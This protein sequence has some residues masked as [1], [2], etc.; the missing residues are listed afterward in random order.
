MSPTFFTASSAISGRPVTTSW[1]KT[2]SSRPSRSLSLFDLGFLDQE[3]QGLIFTN[4]E[5]EII[6]PTWVL[7]IELAELRFFYLHG[8]RHP[9]QLRVHFSRAYSDILGLGYS[10][11][12]EA[13]PYLGLC[14]FLKILQLARQG[15]LDHFVVIP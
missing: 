11:Q 6:S 1:Y 2:V 8:D 5:L 3:I 10:F 14:P 13:G 9:T 7:F 12:E 4:P 15:L